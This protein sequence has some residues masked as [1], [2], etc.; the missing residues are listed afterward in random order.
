[1]NFFA[2]NE[3]LQSLAEVCF[4]KKRWSIEDVRIDG[5]VLR[6]LVINKKH[7]VTNS[8]FLDYHV[9]LHDSETSAAVPKQGYVTSVTRGVLEISEYKAAAAK[10]FEV[11]PFVDWSHF[12]TYEEY[13]VLILNRNKGLVRERER[14]GRRLAEAF[15][16]P[17]LR[18]NDDQ[19]DVLPLAQQWKSRQILGS[20]KASWIIAPEVVEFLQV[21]RRKG[22]LVFSTMRV[23]GRLAAVWI[24]FIY[25]GCWFGWIFTHDPQLAEYSAGHH[26][27]SAMLEHSHELGH[28]EFDFSSGDEDYKMIYAT[29]V[30]LLGPIGRQP[31]WSLRLRQHSR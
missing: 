29:H 12:S 17:V 25:E 6:L 15:G 9:P 1:M 5:H 7:L 11:A 21:L 8:L 28:R 22:L 26:L 16:E 27:V 10:G 4:K 31:L 3:Y 24:G 14:R 30:R 20:G 18:M 2:S 19:D 13:K 23:S